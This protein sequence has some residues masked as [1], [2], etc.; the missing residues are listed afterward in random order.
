[1]K[2]YSEVNKQT[3]KTKNNNDILKFAD[4]WMELGE[5]TILCEVT[6]TQ[7]DKHG[8]FSLISGY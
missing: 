6:H 1:M 3:N 2:Y 7:K 5:K 4:K 8:M